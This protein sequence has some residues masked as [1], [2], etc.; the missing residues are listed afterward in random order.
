MILVI[1]IC[2]GWTETDID[3]PNVRLTRQETG[4]P[5][6]ILYMYVVRFP[7]SVM[8]KF[9]LLKSI[10]VGHFLNTINLLCFTEDSPKYSGIMYISKQLNL[11]LCICSEQ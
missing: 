3:G 4:L 1:H 7:C 9:I 11:L 5:N 8:N 6:K 2:P 10:V